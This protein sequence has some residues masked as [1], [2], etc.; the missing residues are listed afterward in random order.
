M[1]AV[2]EADWTLGTLLSFLSLKVDA[3]EKLVDERYQLQVKATEAAFAA[4]RPSCS[5]Y[6]RDHG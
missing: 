5:W 3:L 2:P 1:N 4:Q 6:C